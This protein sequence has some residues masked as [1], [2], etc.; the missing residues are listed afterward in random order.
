VGLR[1][2]LSNIALFKIAGSIILAGYF[3]L[4]R[5]SIITRAL[6]CGLKNQILIGVDNL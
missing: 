3:F 1:L 4:E 2:A 6:Y 5:T